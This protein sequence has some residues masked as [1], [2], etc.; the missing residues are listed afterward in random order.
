MP[1]EPQTAQSRTVLIWINNA[2]TY[3]EMTD[4][5]RVCRQSMETNPNPGC[6]HTA[7]NCAPILVNT[8]GTYPQPLGTKPHLSE[9]MMHF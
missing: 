4:T 6:R 7:T 5:N 2:N 3:V 8:R 9:S 1:R